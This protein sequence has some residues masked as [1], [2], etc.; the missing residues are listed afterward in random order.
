MTTSHRAP[1][2]AGAFALFWLVLA[3][4]SCSKGSLPSSG[5]QKKLRVSVGEIKE[6]SLS[7][8]SDSA[9]ELIGTSDNQEVVEVSRPQL[10]PAVDTLTNKKS[11]MVFQIKGVTVGTANVIFTT[12]PLNQAGSGQTI[13]TYIVQVTAR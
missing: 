2:T 6:V 4:I 13:R 10:A 5:P 1:K 7:T 8:E 9:A 11:P 3:C 12:K